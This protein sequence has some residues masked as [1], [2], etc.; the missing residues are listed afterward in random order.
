MKKTV[1]IVVIVALVA[2]AGAVAALREDN[3]GPAQTQDVTS[4]TS[5]TP[6][7]DS[8]GSEAETSAQATD[9]VE[10]EDFAYSPQ[11]ITVKKGT[12]VTWT[13]KDTVRHTVTPDDGG[14]FTGSELLAKDQSYSF[15]FTEV[16]E[17][18]YHCQPHP[19]MT[20]SVI[21]TE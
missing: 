1:I 21:V 2:V 17:Y 11:V 18:K 8:N 5:A 12:T 7:P 4:D 13:N 14:T 10:I 6:R 15:T 16:G 3:N 9:E 19:Q 20:G